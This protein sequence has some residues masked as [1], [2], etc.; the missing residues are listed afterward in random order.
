MES[1]ALLEPYIGLRP[2]DR[3]ERALF[4]GRERDEQLLQNKIYSAPLTILYAPS[5][6]GK[7]SLLKTLLIPGLV[8]QGDDVLYVDQ[9]RPEDAYATLT[10]CVARHV[11]SRPDGTGRSCEGLEGLEGLVGLVRSHVQR[12]SPAAF[13]MVLDQFEQVLVDSQ[14]PE[15]MGHDLAMLLSTKLDLH[16]VLSLREEFLARL[17]VFRQYITTLFSSTYRLEHLHD[18]GARQAIE[19]P[20]KAFTPA[21]T[22]DPVLTD[23]LINDLAAEHLSAGAVSNFHHD[24][25]IDLP[26]MQI[27]CQQL[28]RASDH[29]HLT[30]ALYIEMDRR[31]G[32]IK[33]YLD[34][35]TEGLSLAER[36][37]AAEVIDWLAPA[38]GIK[39][40]Y[41]LDILE[42]NTGLPQSKIEAI[43]HHWEEK[44]VIRERDVGN[45]KTYEL[46]HDAFIKV[47]RPW[48]N[49]ILKEKR[50]RIERLEADERTAKE[51][52][53]AA[54]RT[55]RWI[56]STAAAG[57]VC[58]V[59]VVLLLQSSEQEH[60]SDRARTLSLIAARGS[61]N[62]TA[63]TA[64]LRE[65]IDET[66]SR[67]WWERGLSWLM[68]GED[69]PYDLLVL[70]TAPVRDSMTYQLRLDVGKRL[71]GAS[72]VPALGKIVGVASDWTATVWD[73]S[74]T[75]VATF[76]GNKEVGDVTFLSVSPD[77]ASALVRY[78]SGQVNLIAPDGTV[79]GKFAED[80][81]SINAVAFSA[82]GQL[83]VVASDDGASLW[84]RD[85]SLV[86]RLFHGTSAVHAVFSRD[87]SKVATA[88]GNG[89]IAVWNSDGG[90]AWS[91]GAA[92]PDPGPLKSQEQVFRSASYVAFSRDG[93][94]LASASLNGTATLWRIDG[95]QIAL[96]KHDA[97]VAYLAF[98][99]DSLHVLTGSWDGN[100]RLWS[101][102]GKLAAVLADS[103]N[104]S[105]SIDGT[106]I[107][108]SAPRGRARLW[109]RSAT[110]LAD[111]VGHTEA[112]VYAAMDGQRVV[113][114][115]SD[116]TIRIWPRRPFL[117][118][119]LAALPVSGRTPSVVR[120]AAFSPDGQQVLTTFSD[121]RVCLWDPQGRFQ[122]WLPNPGN[123]ASYAAFSRDGTL[124]ATASADGTAH[125]WSRS[126]EPVGVVK[127]PGGALAYAV[128][129][130]KND[131]IITVT[132]RGTITLWTPKGDLIR[133]LKTQRSVTNNA[134]RDGPAPASTFAAS[135]SAYPPPQFSP[136]GGTIL[137]VSNDG[138]ADLWTADGK[139]KE[140]LGEKA[141]KVTYATFAPHG[142]AVLMASTNGTARLWDLQGTPEVVL[143]DEEQG[144]AKP[145]EPFVSKVWYVA[146]SPDGRRILTTRSDILRTHSDTFVRVWD[147]NDP[148]HPIAKI[149]LPKTAFETSGFFRP[150]GTVLTYSQDNVVRL[151][152]TRRALV[153]LAEFGGGSGALEVN[154]G[155]PPARAAISANGEM[156]V[157]MSRESPAR[158]W[159]ITP[160]MILHELQLIEVPCMTKDERQTYFPESVGTSEANERACADKLRKV[161]R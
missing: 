24:E 87:G 14:P 29:Q 106:T 156:I 11:A 40:S 73:L 109:D 107:V 21:F 83:I 62:P 86:A 139:P 9:W 78:A 35:I 7:T 112:V 146:F 36:E 91:R 31:D 8:D 48:S 138:F 104:A 27:V 143:R 38:S 47:I 58:V 97:P 117:V 20:G 45:A 114:A 18:D 101:V 133:E 90:M 151:W 3:K 30:P 17:Q 135:A 63:A 16:I 142:E 10:D 140:G 13:V 102:D 37:E 43:L 147:R 75:Q 44:R 155:P 118:A 148:N 144:P 124:V 4:F 93:E 2:Y 126:G 123:E 94:M 28:W 53:E 95:S 56:W 85:G 98:S 129:S 22:V 103:S 52:D 64:A 158:L 71:L 136:D 130:P 68:G 113:T 111:L 132:R 99:P 149:P 141:G 1:A 79:Q 54:K 128:L 61:E 137:T 69:L 150:D 120:F 96:L 81:A 89:T 60:R 108:S 115:S 74:G 76:K 34:T 6:V 25:G 110:P 41:P 66:L 119:R 122:R 33:K 100:T 157:T 32:I 51:R 67:P 153:P 42:K 12:I 49:Q 57:L 152:D 84:N 125:V 121:G 70:S 92:A 159:A 127:D 50:E 46:Y 80:V 5:G 145:D 105:F 26:V 59:L 116:G 39:M 131:S 55:R 72:F 23:T 82:N 154:A 161:P 77:L 19:G 134:A 160:S 65:V 15:D 88:D